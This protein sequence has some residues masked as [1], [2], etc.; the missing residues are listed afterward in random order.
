MENPYQVSGAA[1]GSADYPLA[2]MAGIQ[3]MAATKSWVRLCA[4]IGFVIGG[5]LFLASLVGFF[6]GFSSAAGVAELA[7]RVAAITPSL[8]MSILALIVSGK[9]WGYGSAIARLLVTQAPADMDRAL[10]AQRRFW[11]V[12]G[13]ILILWLV[14]MFFLLVFAFFSTPIRH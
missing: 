2:S 4:V 9:L 7:F 6:A 10:D 11:R 13:I 1:G 14:L 12:A 8:I 3:S 5:I